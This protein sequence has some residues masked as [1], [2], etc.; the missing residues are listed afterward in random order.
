MVRVLFELMVQLKDARLQSSH[1]LLILADLGLQ[2]RTKVYSR[3][4]TVDVTLV[5][6]RLGLGSACEDI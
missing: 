5:L 1:M 4:Q 2:Q 3:Y 6:L